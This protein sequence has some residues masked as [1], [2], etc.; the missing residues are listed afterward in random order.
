M[1]SAS[2]WGSKHTRTVFPQLMFRNGI[3]FG[4]E[5]LLVGMVGTCQCPTWIIL[6]CDYGVLR[7]P[8]KA[9]FIS[10]LLS[11]VSFFTDRWH[12]QLDK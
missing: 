2:F 6:S 3:P 10:I 5:I 12:I 9:P 1:V 11:L 4:P 8:G 7:A